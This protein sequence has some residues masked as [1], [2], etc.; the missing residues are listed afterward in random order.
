MLHIEAALFF[1]KYN[2]SI[3]FLLLI[4]TR[5]GASVS[6]DFKNGGAFEENKG[7]YIDD[8]NDKHSIK[9]ALNMGEVKVYVR[10]SGLSYVFNRINSEEDT[11]DLISF[12]HP[13]YENETHRVDMI[14]KNAN[15][16]PKISHYNETK[17]YI[18]YY[19]HN[20]LHIK[21]YERLIVHDV[22]PNIDWELM[23]V[24][25]RLKYNFIVHPYGNS[26]DIKMEYKGQDFLYL[27]LDGGLIIQ[28]KLGDILENAPQT[29]Q[30]DL[31][32]KS[33]FFIY[34]N[35]VQFQVNEYDANLSLIIDP[36]IQWSTYY[37]G[38]QGNNIKTDTKG[39][40][41]LSG[42]T[43]FANSS[44]PYLG[45]QMN[46]GGSW[47]DGFLVK[48]NSNGVRIWASYYGGPGHDDI[49]SLDI[50]S[51]DNIFV[52][53]TT[54]S[55]TNIA[56]NG[57]LNT[58][59][60]GADGYIAKFDSSGTRLWA[61]YFGGTQSD[62]LPS[63]CVGDSGC[64]YIAGSA[65]S[66]SLAVNGYKMTRDSVDGFIAKINPNIGVKWCTYVGGTLGDYIRTCSYQDGY[67]YVSGESYSTIFP[68]TGN[69]HQAS[70]GGGP[71]DAFI[72]KYT[73][74]GI[75]VWSTF[76]GGSSVDYGL[77]I[78]VRKNNLWL[79]GI[80]QSTNNISHNG[81][82]NTYGGGIRD[83]FLLKMD[84]SGNRIWSTYYGG[85]GIE[86]FYTSGNVLDSYGI[87]LDENDNL[88]LNLGTNSTG[89]AYKGI[90]S[91]IAGGF[92]L[93][94]AKFRPDGSRIWSS[95]FGG[96]YSDYAG[97]ICIRDKNTFYISGTSQSPTGIAQNGHQNTL[98]SSGQ[99]A[100]LTK[101]ICSNDT[102]FSDTVCRGDTF[103]FGSNR[104]TLSGTYH[105]TLDNWE[106]CDSFITLHLTVLRKDTTYLYDTI[107]SGIGYV[108][109]GTN[110]TMS[111]VYRDTILNNVNCDSFLVLNLHIKRT[112]TIHLYD[113][114]CANLPKTFNG[115]NITLAGVYR[116]TLKNI[117]GCDSHIFY[118]FIPKPVYETPVSRAI[119][120]GDSSLF[121]GKYYRQA[122]IYYD[123]LNARHGCDS[124]LKLTLTINPLDTNRQ[125]QAICRGK[126]YNFYSQVLTSQGTYS[127]KFT[128]RNGCD[129]TILLTLS[130]IDSAT[131]SFSRMLCSGQSLL[132][133]NQNLTQAGVY[134]DTFMNYLGCDSFVTLNLSF[135]L[136]LYDT[137]RQRVCT[138]Q[139]FRGYTSPGTYKETYKSSL[140]CDSILT[141][142]LK[143]L[144]ATEYKTVSHSKCGAFLYD[145]RTF[146][147][148]DS[149]T[150]IIQNYLNCDSIVTKHIV[151]ITKPNP[152]VLEPKSIPFCE[153]ILH[154]NQAKTQ[155]FYT[156]D[157]VKS[158]EYP[159]CDSLYQPIFYQ[160]E[161]RPDLAIYAASDTVVRGQP[162]QLSA[163]LANHYRWNTGEQTT[164]IRPKIEESTIFTVR[165]WNLEN[166]ESQTSISITAIEPLIIDFP[167]AFSP[168]GD[169]LNDSFY[170]NTNQNVIIESFDIY[171]RIGE[172]VYSYTPLSP[173]WNGFYLGQPAAAGVYSYILNYRFLGNRFTKTG[174]V[175][176]VR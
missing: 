76:Y 107:C 38:L 18:N 50:D 124:L 123:T 23:I 130:V 159:Y 75:L 92:D 129:S 22:Y 47:M 24:D 127:H 58:Y 176:L 170:P 103:I 155:S 150:E 64:I 30:G 99:D 118:H 73:S 149:F 63:I 125:T 88:F 153:E 112:D 101:F 158:A 141:I 78:L 79:F 45:H 104:L 142:Y 40:V 160:R 16:N 36:Y 53:G 14:L 20:L 51:M 80:T 140:G 109:N 84:S 133:N 105:D 136:V 89:L 122:G 91:S 41:Y 49:A 147:Q 83:A 81:F 1:M 162:I 85:S 108:W 55:N 42:Y 31:K 121:G 19:N 165:G 39:N 113:T 116:D 120:S 131:Y 148:N 151:T 2:L 71:R 72:C 13:K 132:F 68:H 46:Y 54:Y 59:Q 15:P 65:G 11:S 168:N 134:R 119:C 52:V 82:Q 21:K 115:Q 98:S 94:I 29:F 175:M 43:S 117:V 70:Y 9:Y 61:S 114:S 138:G 167:T 32:I 57:F 34:K 96:Q 111:G 95:Y 26:N 77:K 100:F 145:N 69:I 6:L 87:D 171:N 102:T 137:L 28:T 35:I 25:G 157:T 44:L 17:D 67:I 48:F 128:N 106:Y 173:S 66:N 4:V 27:N 97:G 156:Q 8:L 7:Q 12:D 110:R 60:G 143:H 90:K 146:T 166:C 5:L 74:N 86:A 144:P 164:V 37:P 135:G 161:V 174:E 152:M 62:Y 93:C 10:N 169:G 56:Y 172:K 154:R 3:F 126:S 163:A 139:V 33:N